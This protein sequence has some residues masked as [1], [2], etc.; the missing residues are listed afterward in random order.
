VLGLIHGTRRTIISNGAA[1]T[2]ELGAIG[3]TRFRRA[4]RKGL[5][6][7]HNIVLSNEDL[8]EFTVTFFHRMNIADVAYHSLY[9]RDPSQA[10]ETLVTKF[11]KGT[12]AN[13]T[14]VSY[15]EPGQWDA[16]PTGRL[17]PDGS[18]E[19]R[20]C[21][22][23][24]GEIQT[25][26]VIQLPNHRLHCNHVTCRDAP[27]VGEVVDGA[28]Q[29]RTHALRYRCCPG[30]PEH[31]ASEVVAFISR[32]EFVSTDENYPRLFRMKRP[33]RRELETI[34]AD[35]HFLRK[36]HFMDDP[37]RPQRLRD[38]NAARARARERADAR[39]PDQR[40]GETAAAYR[41]RLAELARTRVALGTRPGEYTFVAELCSEVTEL[42]E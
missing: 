32:I 37:E 11:A 35:R 19:F 9:Y 16:E 39:P 15:V 26:A 2:K 10:P 4:V 6:V 14:V 13:S 22:E 28:W 41:T 3:D 25:F 7:R 17:N 20:Q 12:K 34:D 21:Q 23:S 8:D 27:M 42:G 29:C 33:A 36:M 24:T 5:K 30:N 40:P 18:P 38:L 31:G 1:W